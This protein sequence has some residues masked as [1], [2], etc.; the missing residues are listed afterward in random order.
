MSTVGQISMGDGPT[1]GGGAVGVKQLRG[2]QRW[3]EQAGYIYFITNN[4]NDC[5]LY[6]SS[7]GETG[8]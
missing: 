7:D 4:C 3:S 2:M 8:E 6:W 5:V 1:G